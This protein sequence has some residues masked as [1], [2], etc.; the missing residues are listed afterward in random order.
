MSNRHWNF[1]VMVICTRTGKIYTVGTTKEALDMLLNAWP[2]A[3]GKAFMMALQI[4][5][6]VESGIRQPLEARNSFVAAAKE[7]GV[8]IET[9]MAE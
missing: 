3:E 2:V 7:A 5:T 8:P 9:T 4:C 1:P 6:D